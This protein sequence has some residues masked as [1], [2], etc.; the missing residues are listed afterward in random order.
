MPEAAEF[1]PLEELEALASQIPA[2]KD[3]QRLGDALDQAVQAVSEAENA[4]ARLE[5]VAELAPVVGAFLDPTDAEQCR[6][7]MATIRGTGTHLC[8]AHD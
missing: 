7:L 3:R 8:Q 5:R 4:I 1:D 6:Q 2:A